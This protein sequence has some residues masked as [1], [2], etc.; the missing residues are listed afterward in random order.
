MLG[1]W[2]FF[3]FFECFERFSTGSWD[4]FTSGSHLSNGALRWS[5]E[6]QEGRGRSW[7]R[8]VNFLTQWLG[9]DMKEG[10]ISTDRSIKRETDL[11]GGLLPNIDPGRFAVWG[12]FSYRKSTKRQDTPCLVGQYDDIWPGSDW[13]AEAL[14]HQWPYWGCWDCWPFVESGGA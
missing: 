1:V 3:V 12:F 10:L 4:G 13:T 5:M 8:M 7:R 11:A 6:R 9:S 14:P 2:R